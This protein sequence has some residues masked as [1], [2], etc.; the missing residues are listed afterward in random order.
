ML[1]HQDYAVELFASISHS[2]IFNPH[3]AEINFRRQKDE[4]INIFL[5]AI[6]P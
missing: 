1:T 5:M 6:D 2:F 4:R 3:S